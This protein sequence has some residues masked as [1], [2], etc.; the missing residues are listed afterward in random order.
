MS[1]IEKGL[2]RARAALHSIG[3]PGLAEL[4]PMPDVGSA[5]VSPS[6]GTSSDSGW[7]GT[8]RRSG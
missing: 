6:L 4:A 8:G 2:K 5:A 1:N 3:S 7:R